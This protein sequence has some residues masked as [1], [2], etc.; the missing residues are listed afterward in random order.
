MKIL[1]QIV[2][3]L[4]RHAEEEV[5]LE[6]CGYLA[7]EDN[8]IT[9]LFRMTN[10]D[11][12]EDH[13]SFDP[14]EQFKILK[15][16]RKEGFELL[17]VYHSH[18]ATPARPS[19]ED[20][21]FAYDPS[22]SHVILS[23][24]GGKKVVKSFRIV[25]GKVTAEPLDIIR[26]SKQ[27]ITMF[28]CK[29]PP[30]L[31]LDINRLEQDLADYME[32]KL[33]ET[34][35]T[36]KRVK[37]GIYMERSYKTYM[38]RIRC[39]GNLIT[40]NQ[41]KK[42]AELALEY[43][44]SRVHVTTRAE[45]QIH[46]IGLENI[47]QVL[48]ELAACGLTSK[49]GGGHTVRNIITNHDSGINPF[50]LFD[51]QPYAATLTSRLISEVDSFELPRKFKTGFSSTEDDSTNCVLQDLGFI[52]QI[53][54]KGE[55]GFQ[56]YAGGGLGANPKTGIL[57]HD[58]LPEG[59]VFH[60]VKALKNVFHTHGNRK[61]KQ[62]NRM[63]FLIH[64]DLGE[65]QFRNLYREALDN[66]YHDD[67]LKF[68][69]KT[70][71]NEENQNCQFRLEPCMGEIEG[72]ETWFD[73]NV[74]SQKQA[75]LFGIKLPLNLGDLSCQDC[76]KLVETLRPFGENVLRCGSDQNFYI[77]N[78]PEKF[79]RNMYECIKGL[80]TLSDR[81]V[82]FGN[83]VPCTGAQTCLV[84]I[85]YPRPATVAIFKQFE[86]KGLDY[87]SL[88]ELKIRISGCPNSCANHWIG[89]LAFY[90]KVRRVNG[91]P[92][93]TYNVI[94]GACVKGDE[95][96]LAEEVGWVHSYDLPEF[97][98]DVLENYL[99]FKSKTKSQVD[100]LKYWGDSG[101]EFIGHLCKT[102]YNTI[103]TFEKDKNYYFDH[104]AKDLFSVKDVGR[105]E[106][107]A[108]IYDMIDVDVRI[109]RKNIEIVEAGG[110]NSD[111]R[112]TALEKIT[113]S[114]SRMLLVTRG[115][116]PRTDREIYDLFLKHFIDTGLVE[117]GNREVLETFRD[118]NSE[119]LSYYS[120][121]IKSLGKEVIVLY[122]GMD[123]TM[124]FPGETENLAITMDAR[125]PQ[126][127][128]TAPRPKSSAA[129]QEDEMKVD[130]FKDLR[131]VKCPINFAQTKVQL[132]TMKPGEIL[133]IYLDDGEP[134]NNV[135]G[136]VKLEG[137]KILNQENVG[138]YW[139]VVIE[140][141]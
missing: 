30:T 62:R 20:I 72:Y 60:V 87:D 68:E 64:D 101:K 132:A 24:A 96:R 100:F 135:P 26:R 121:K 110:A 4:Y 59:K 40:P 56:V 39:A 138:E 48:R 130:K 33:H 81:P 51:V 21:R 85:N 32:G 131:G 98:T 108:G 74:I 19:E 88:H 23:L 41:L 116:D 107:S 139:D 105:A 137:H 78:I 18:P 1:R 17:A 10:V 46:G 140:K 120:D 79:L 128:V 75:G 13:F 123:N 90:G 83:L 54:E 94:G 12:S 106:C 134:I 92:I 133:E 104:G 67:G 113:F 8:I 7:G 65:D 31:G 11:Q 38:C 77:R 76:F 45:V 58:F 114:A 99:D 103:P 44:D 55:K 80:Q 50:E 91:H 136:S 28:S 25:D 97:I 141:A 49:G 118:R 27:G 119:D 71:D 66:I 29:L 127:L 22:V 37:M 36:A 9:K 2:S 16:A 109:I 6:A 42:T 63:R 115:E 3:D 57:L 82:M 125:A 89:D 129:K 15:A 126:P 112:N 111:E 84:G 69:I 93:P 70:I 35:F 47:T 86:R 61:N 122:E 124:R 5:P 53:N 102:R 52:A 73:R 117:A 14:M 34:A 43:G 95:T